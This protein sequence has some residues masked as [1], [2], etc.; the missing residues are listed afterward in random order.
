MKTALQLAAALC[1]HF[2][3]TRLDVYL[4]PANLL[5]VGTGHLVRLEDGLQLGDRIDT[6]S[7]EHFLRHDLQKAKQIA[8]AAAASWHLMGECRRAVLIDVAF[9]VPKALK[10][11]TGLRKALDERRLDDV[12][13]QLARWVY[14]GKTKLPGLVRRRDA[15]ARLWQG[16]SLEAVLGAPAA[17]SLPTLRRGDK[18]PE[19]RELQRKLNALDDLRYAAPSTGYFGWPTQIAV[20]MFQKEHSL[21]VDGIAGP[22]TWA[23]LAE[24]LAEKAGLQ[25]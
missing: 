7:A 19:V 21:T 10:P 3:G 13:A 24:R 9:N 15:E 1:R 8:Y 12:P 11:G 25:G 14:A 22:K 20:L 23:K 5:T 17:P 4:D 16:E 2:E 6:A 18:G